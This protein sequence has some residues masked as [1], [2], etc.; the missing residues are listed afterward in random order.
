MGN[1]LDDINNP[2]DL[3]ELTNIQLREIAE[4]IRDFLI[5]HVSQTGGHLASNLGIVELTLALHKVFNLP[6]D[7]IVWDVGHQSYVHKI[8]TG[9]KDEF[10]NLRKLN[11]ISGFP[12]T[13]ESEYDS[14]NTG[15]SSTSISAAMGMAKARD[16]AGKNHHVIAVIGDG[17]LTGGMAYE[18]LNH[19]GQEECKL[20]V[21]LN[22]NQMSIVHNV[23]SMAKYLNRIRSK[24]SYYKVKVKTERFL[25]KI[26]LIGEFLA[27]LIYRIKGS[28][29]YFFVPGMLFEELGFS[30][31][32]PINGYSLE[33]LTSAFQRAKSFDRPILLHVY[34]KKGKGY[35]FAEENPDEYHGVS[36]FDVTTGNSSMPKSDDVSLS[37]C[38]GNQLCKIASQN[39]KVVAI[40][41]AMALGTG[42]MDYAYRYPKRFFDVGIAEQH[43]VT[44]AAGMAS[45]G[46]RPVVAIYSTF[47]QR[48]YDQIL[49][50]VCLQNLSVVFCL[51]RSGIVGRDGETHHGIFDL[52][53]LSHMPNMAIMAPSSPKMLEEMLNYAVNKHNGPI[54]LRY[55][56][57]I[58]NY[59]TAPFRFGKAEILQEGSDVTLISVGDM[60]EIALETIKIAKNIS[61]ELIDLRTVK[62][63]DMETIQES[64]DKTKKVIVLENNCTSGGAGSI[65]QSELKQAQVL[66]IGFPVD[67]VPS[68]GSNEELFRQYGLD[69]DAIAQEIKRFIGENSNA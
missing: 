46:Y 14:F 56:K 58:A 10:D 34:T 6:E 51:D 42:L 29:K 38:F 30:Y 53:Y 62:P 45:Q 47:L 5:K 8:I 26:P 49:H 22:D 66:K 21:V 69:K 67:H 24:P 19:A 36:K 54:T 41:A 52:S 48:A 16:L 65:I 44:F 11:G 15:H 23:G 27:K 61:I 1:R 43:A 64:A 35:S 28:L 59:P 40:S 31:L 9:R 63:V 55:P 7:K 12:K 33:E 13:S 50:D 4:E 57:A 32:G 18:A 3:K 17:A 60:L 37:K 2:G 68:H 25:R 39:K 20:I